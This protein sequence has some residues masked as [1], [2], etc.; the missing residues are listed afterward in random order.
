MNCWM[1]SIAPTCSNRRCTRDRWVLLRPEARNGSCRRPSCP[2]PEAEVITIYSPKGGTGC[3]TLTVNLAIA[4]QN[5]LGQEAKICLVD[6]N[7]Q[8]GDVSVFMKLQPSRTLA[9]LA[10][11]AADLDPHLLD[12]ILVTHDSGVRVLCA[13]ASPE[14]AEIFREGGVEGVGREQPF[15]HDSRFS[16]TAV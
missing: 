11:H 16:A 12:S 2:G 3:T 10:P 4:L 13:P 9:D 15:S 5:M 1:P 6:G 7:L 14:E 8:F